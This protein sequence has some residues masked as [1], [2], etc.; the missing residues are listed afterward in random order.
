MILNGRDKGDLSFAYENV[1][2]SFGLCFFQQGQ[3]NRR[4]LQF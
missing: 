2:A 1:K 3:Q 4:S